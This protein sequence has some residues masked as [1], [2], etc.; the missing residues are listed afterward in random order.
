LRLISKR[1]GLE[2]ARGSL[3]KLKAIRRSLY[4]VAKPTVTDLIRYLYSMTV[5]KALTL[6][7][8]LFR[9]VGLV[10]KAVASTYIIA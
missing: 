8:Y 7:M 10:V 9:P 3:L 6:F 4:R 1:T 5:N 2:E